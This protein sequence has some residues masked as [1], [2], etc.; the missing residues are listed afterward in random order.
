MKK[1]TIL[2]LTF[3]TLGLATAQA[4]EQVPW[5]TQEQIDQMPRFESVEQQ[6]CPKA[7]YSSAEELQE[8][9]EAVR[10]ELFE[11]QQAEKESVVESEAPSPANNYGGHGHAH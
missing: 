9:K 10:M 6:R 3:A 11:K 8:C 5:Y 4:Q 1:L 2:T 7:D